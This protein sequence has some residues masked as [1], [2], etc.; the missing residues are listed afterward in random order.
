VCAIQDVRSYKEKR[1]VG[2]YFDRRS[3]LD[4]IGRSAHL[5]SQPA[6]GVLPEWRTR[7]DPFDSNHSASAGPNLGGRNVSYRPQKMVQVVSQAG[8]EVNLKSA[9]PK[10]RRVK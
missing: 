1:Y 4:V 10:D 2:N 9:N 5:A 3:G 6:V 7:P 8:Y